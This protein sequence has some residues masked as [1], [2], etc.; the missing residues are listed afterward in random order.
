VAL[1][2]ADCNTYSNTGNQ[3]W[4]ITSADSY[5][6][7]TSMK[8]PEAL[9]NNQSCTI[10]TTVSGYSSL[11]FYWKVSS[12]A[13]YDYLEF[14]IDGVRQD[15]IAGTVAWQQKSYTF[16]T[17][18]HTVK[19]VYDKDVSVSS[20]SDCGWVDGVVFGTGGGTPTYCDAEGTNTS[21]EWIARVRV[22][23]I[24]K[25][26][27]ADGYADYTST[28]G[29]LT[30]GS[31][32]SVTLTPG[33]ASSS[34]TE[35]WRIWVDYNQDGDFDDT[36]ELVYS[37]TG[38]SSVSGSFT[39]PTSASTGNTRMRVIMKYSSAASSCGSFTYGEVEDYTVNIQ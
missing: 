9:G 17:G 30:K 3:L 4:E 36:G 23:D 29:N 6:G 19:W 25:S 32:A 5:V 35:Y 39:P 10:Q 8:A 27:G 13:N 24:D 14:Y 1:D 11:S 20:G 2:D 12:E 18:S 31:S 38:S 15:R 21:Y 26:S 16:S 37:G 28:T 34:Y 33:F 7:T 22:A